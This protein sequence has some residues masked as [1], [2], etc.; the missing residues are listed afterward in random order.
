[1]KHIAFICLLLEVLAYLLIVWTYKE[2]VYDLLGAMALF[3]TLSVMAFIN[4]ED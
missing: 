4:I 1:M 2:L 3:S